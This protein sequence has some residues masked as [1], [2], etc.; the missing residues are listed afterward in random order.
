MIPFLSRKR[1]TARPAYSGFGSS[2]KSFL[3][4]NLLRTPACPSA[5]RLS[6][7]AAPGAFAAPRVTGPAILGPLVA[8]QRCGFDVPT[9]KDRVPAKD[10][11]AAKRPQPAALWSEL[12]RRDAQ[13]RLAC[14]G[15][16]GPPSASPASFSKGKGLAL[17]SPEA[18][19]K[20][21]RG[22]L[23]RAVFSDDQRR[24]L[25]R[26]FERQKY[27][28]KAD[29]NK[30]SADLGLKESQVKIWF[31]NRRMKWRN[32]KEK[33]VLCLRSLTEEM[34][35]R[36]D[37]GT[38]E[39]QEDREAQGGGVEPQ[40]SVTGGGTLADYMTNYELCVHREETTR[41]LWTQLNSFSD[42]P[43]PKHHLANVD[44]GFAIKTENR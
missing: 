14:C 24:A 31:Q 19:P 2:G 3:I 20:S 21:R 8:V 23:R 11:A 44:Q 29:R 33:E 10:G 1:E 41:E 38:E 40:L 28:S 34:S 4:E 32:S 6:A 12:F 22:I 26:T 16:S 25:E 7:S 43:H 27:I 37:P 9:D 42:C 36:S 39:E 30:L 5:H 17:W 13:I 15:G 18:S 35:L